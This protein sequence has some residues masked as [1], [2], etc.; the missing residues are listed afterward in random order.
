LK[1]ETL[2]SPW[3]RL[4]DNIGMDLREI[5]WEGADWLHLAQVRDQWWAFV[6]MVMILWVP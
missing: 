2:G 6:N 1:G 3:H 5:R 4:G